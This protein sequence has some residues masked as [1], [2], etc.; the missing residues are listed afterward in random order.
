MSQTSIIIT[1]KRRNTAEG[2]RNARSWF[3]GAP[4]LGNAPWPRDDK[5]QPLHFAAQIDMEELATVAGATGLP[6]TGSLAF[7]I[8]GRGC[9]TYVPAREA[10]QTEP[11]V[12]APDLHENYAHNLWRRD[13]LGRPLFPKA[14]IEFTVA[15]P[16]AAPPTRRDERMMLDA[17]ALFETPLPRW[18]QTALHLRDYLD[19][20]EARLPS[21]EALAIEV[22]E[23]SRK[24]LAETRADPPAAVRKEVSYPVSKEMLDYECARIVAQAEGGLTNSEKSLATIRAMPPRLAAFKSEVLGLTSGRDAWSLMGPADWQKLEAL[25]RR[26]P[27]FSEVTDRWGTLGIIDLQNEMFQALPAADTPAFDAI[28]ASV[29]AFI[30]ERRAPRPLWWIA[31]IRFADSLRHASDAFIP[32]SI[33]QCR[34]I[35]ALCERIVNAPDSA[36]AARAAQKDPLCHWQLGGE[37]SAIELQRSVL[38]KYLAF[39]PPFRLFAAEVKDWVEAHDPWERM[40]PEDI[41]AFERYV[42]RVQKEYLGYLGSV[43]YFMSDVENDMLLTMATAD[44]ERTYRLLPAVARDRLDNGFRTALSGRHQLFGTGSDIQGGASW[45]I[46]LERRLLLQL[47][48]DDL[49]RWRFGDVGVI[50]FWMSPFNLMTRRWHTAHILMEGH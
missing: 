18:W 14:A 41:A 31:A 5:G 2:W 4:R 3:G 16:A 15:A 46:G 39:E 32:Q 30:V 48:Y 26:V 34:A 33:E 28:P 29:R 27:E 40:A 45:Q 23:L 13:L 21:A 8:G 25:W 24:R 38:N 17:K 50:Q 35:I 37:R 42:R 44:D 1:R 20:A 10:E 11:P 43:A 19:E 47:A 6:K 7:F 36:S 49:Q 12:G 9:V 22:I